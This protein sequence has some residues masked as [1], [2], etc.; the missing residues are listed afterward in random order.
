MSLSASNQNAAT[1]F[2]ETNVDLLEYAKTNRD[3]GVFNDVTLQFGNLSIEANRM[4]LAC[5][6]N[7]FETMF[8]YKM[9]ERYESNIPITGVD[10]NIAR[11]LVDYMYNAQIKID[12]DSVMDI[13]A[14]ADYFQLDAVKEFCFEYLMN[15]MSLDNRYDVQTAAELYRSDQLQKQVNEFITK[16]FDEVIQTLDF[17]TFHETSFDFIFV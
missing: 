1:R 15:R 2:R 5:C 7:Y 12:N 13:L 4:V 9:K 14:G 10:G 3:E 17:K 6:S 11:T 8:K 16:Y